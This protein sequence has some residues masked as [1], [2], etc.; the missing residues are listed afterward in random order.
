MRVSY[1]RDRHSEQRLVPSHDRL[2]QVE[3]AQSLSTARVPRP[4]YGLLLLAC[5][6]ALPRYC[7]RRMVNNGEG[8]PRGSQND[9]DTLSTS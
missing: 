2:D 9:G 6:S 7:I 8:E 3:T 1:M 5:A 4:A